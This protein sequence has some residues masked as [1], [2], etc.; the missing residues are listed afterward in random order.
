MD[1]KGLHEQMGALR[2]SQARQEESLRTLSGERDRLDHD[3]EVLKEDIARLSEDNQKYRTLSDS[4]DLCRQICDVLDIFVSDY[5]STRIGQ[6]QS[7]VNRKFQRADQRPW[8]SQLYRN[9]P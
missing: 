4:L 8:S 7:I 5:R 9:R 6:L 1:V 3:S 2:T